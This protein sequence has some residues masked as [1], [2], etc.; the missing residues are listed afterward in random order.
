MV[1]FISMEQIGV[2]EAS[3]LERGMTA[4]I[5]ERTFSHLILILALSK[6]LQKSPSPSP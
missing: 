1:P 6:A 2:M 4:P 3:H 5:L